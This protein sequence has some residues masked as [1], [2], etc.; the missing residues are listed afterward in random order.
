MKGAILAAA[1]VAGLCTGADAVR[2]YNTSSK[3]LRGVVNV[4]LVPVRIVGVEGEGCCCCSRGLE[5][6]SKKLGV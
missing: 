1:L 6:V 5:G 3:R 4:H 2:N